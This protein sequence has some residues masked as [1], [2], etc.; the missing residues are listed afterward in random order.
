MQQA[1]ELYKQSNGRQQVLP[2]DSIYRKALPEWNKS[3]LPVS[4]FFY[5]DFITG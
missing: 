5:I 2:L 1:H 3:V 4:Q